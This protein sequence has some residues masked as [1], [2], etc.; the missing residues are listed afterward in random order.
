MTTPQAPEHPAP[1]PYAFTPTP[2]DS[3]KVVRWAR[4]AITLA[5]IPLGLSA[6]RS[7][8]GRVP[9]LG[10]IDTA[11]HEFGHMLFMPFGQAVLGDTM[12]ILGGSLLQVALPLVFVG[13]FLFSKDHRDVHAGTVCLWWAGT[14]LLSVSIYAA[15]AR[16]RQLMLL[17]GATGQED[18]SGHDFYNLFSQWGV[19]ERD[20]L[21]AGRLRALAVLMCF[22]AIAVGLFVALQKPIEKPAEE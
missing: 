22:S 6:F 4:I 5:L 18:D 14:S 8:Y 15:D 17:S 19:L 3:P 7:E 21:Y 16:A 10:D 13:Y 1:N 9:L 12:V 2:D 20:T 11:I